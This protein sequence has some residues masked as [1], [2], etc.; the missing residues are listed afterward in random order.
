M[1]CIL[2]CLSL[3]NRH[4]SLIRCLIDD[5]VDLKSLSERS[6]SC[7]LVKV[8]DHVVTRRL[9]QPV[10]HVITWLIDWLITL[11]KRLSCESCG[12]MFHSLKRSKF[13]Y[14]TCHHIW[15]VNSLTQMKRWNRSLFD[16]SNVVM[17]ICETFIVWPRNKWIPQWILIDPFNPHSNVDAFGQIDM[18][19]M[20]NR[21]FIPHITSKWSTRPTH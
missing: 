15:F 9:N 11:S 12:N 3:Y 17:T 19:N 16:C 14:V 18:N 5:V 4:L 13:G 6:M 7:Q 10:S 2:V 8:L 20:T 21:M 1:K